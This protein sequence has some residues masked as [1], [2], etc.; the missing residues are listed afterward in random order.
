MKSRVALFEGT[1][2]KYFKNTAFVP[3]GPGWPG[4]EKD[5]NA[6]YQY[7]TGDIDSEINYFLTLAMDA[8]GSGRCCCLG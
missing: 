4:K 3:N 6:N 7:P 5:Y 1:W 2:L 8:S